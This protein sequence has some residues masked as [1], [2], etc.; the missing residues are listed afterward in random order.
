MTNHFNSASVSME[1]PPSRLAE[2]TP[3]DSQD[4]TFI[5]TAI[6]VALSGAVR[7]TTVDGDTGSVY[8]AAG[9]SFPLRVTRIWATGT[10]AENIR[11]LADTIGAI[12]AAIAGLT[13]GIARIGDYASL[14]VTPP[15]GV[16]WVSQTWGVG[17]Y[18]DDTYGTGT[19]PANY[20][21]SDALLL[22]WQGLG[23]DGNTYRA[24]AP[25]RYAA[26]SA[27]GVLVD[28][29]F[30]INTGVQ[31][32]DVSGD[33]SGTGLTFT[34]SLTMAPT[35]VTVNAATGLASHDTGAMSEQTDTNVVVRATDQYGRTLSSGYSVT[36]AAANDA[37]VINTFA[38]GEQSGQQQLFTLDLSEAATVHFALTATA[39]KPTPQRVVDGMD[40]TGGAAADSNS[41]AAP[42]AATYPATLRTGLAGPYYFQIVAEDS[43]GALSDV[44][45]VGPVDVDTTPP[46]FVL[47]VPSGN[48]MGVAINAAPALE[49][50]ENM[51]STG[52]V[53]L[54]DVTGAAVTETFDLAT[55]TGDNGGTVAV[56]ADQVTVTPGADLAGSNEYAIRTSGLTDTSGNAFAD[57]T[58][59][60][61]LNFTT[62]AAA[63]GY[64]ENF[65]GASYQATFAGQ[66]LFVTNVDGLA[67]T[68][69]H[70]PAAGAPT[71]STVGR[72]SFSSTGGSG[73]ARVRIPVDGSTDFSTLSADLGGTSDNNAVA[74]TGRFAWLDVNEDVIGS[75]FNEIPEV[76][77]NRFTEMVYLGNHLPLP[78]AM[79]ANARFLAIDIGI[80]NILTSFVSNLGFD[81]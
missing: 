78:V 28:Q 7:V 38:L 57:I 4:L 25:I 69:S 70:S 30:T 64:A 35:G 40:H 60:M 9:I 53:V 1:S 11:G 20:A 14:S 73:Y 22:L 23:D 80:T 37:P 41:F 48:A 50:S 18:G 58:D 65:Q 47:S 43:Q 31:T 26:G 34:F 27:A 76:G 10:T 52:T 39:D 29:P 74:R 55:G 67:S 68:A 16:V 63:A 49:F 8:I 12:A 21:A 24:Y 33:F 45:T 71:G 17:T 59:D 54:R 32:Y 19:N 5:T 51:A 15:N 77:D 6:N 36:I 44:S 75:F 56:S 2:I 13:E 62:V 66:Q 79:P 3:S 72:L 42:S 46:T 61:S 81:F